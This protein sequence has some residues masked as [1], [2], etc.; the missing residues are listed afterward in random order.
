MHVVVLGPKPY[1]P[2]LVAKLRF[3]GLVLSAAFD[4]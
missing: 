4:H 1:T 3:G 2:V